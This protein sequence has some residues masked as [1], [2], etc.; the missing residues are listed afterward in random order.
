MELW[1]GLLLAPEP[2]RRARNV[3][4]KSQ[5]RVT[6]ILSGL[7]LLSWGLRQRPVTYHHGYGQ[8]DLM[9]SLS[10]SWIISRPKKIIMPLASRQQSFRGI[11][12]ARTSL[13]MSSRHAD[14]FTRSHH[15]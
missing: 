4:P 14:Y 1:R 9:L 13:G 6:W 3:S 7:R 12:S 15:G 11:S 8:L 5:R 10:L 2:V